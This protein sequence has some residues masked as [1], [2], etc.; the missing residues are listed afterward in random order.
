MRWLGFHYLCDYLIDVISTNIADS[1]M[2]V[3]YLKPLFFV[4]FFFEWALLSL[5]FKEIKLCVAE[6]YFNSNVCRI[7]ARSSFVKLQFSIKFSS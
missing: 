1:M 6:L 4:Y 5:K 2:K 3:L 7:S